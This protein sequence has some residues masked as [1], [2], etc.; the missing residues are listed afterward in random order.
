MRVQTFGVTDSE[1]KVC[2]HSS[3][4]LSLP[5]I[6][7]RLEMD[8]GAWSILSSRTL[9]SPRRLQPKGHDRKEIH[10]TEENKTF[11]C[12]SGDKSSIP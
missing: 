2:R 11:Y 4:A 5:T 7:H 1:K 9:S 6:R 3:R 12:S 10:K 8:I